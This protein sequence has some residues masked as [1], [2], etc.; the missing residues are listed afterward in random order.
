MDFEADEGLAEPAI[1]N[2]RSLLWLAAGP[3]D[4]NVSR[5]R[6]ERDG[7]VCLMVIAQPVEGAQ[8]VPDISG[9]ESAGPE[10]H[11]LLNVHQFMGDHR[12][13]PAAIVVS[14]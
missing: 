10:F 12:S 11:E 2:E 7:Q 5:L 8:I 9:Q 6:L 4:G 13:G 1:M 14:A 3:L